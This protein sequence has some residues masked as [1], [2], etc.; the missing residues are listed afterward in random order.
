MPSFTTLLINTCNIQAKTQSTGSYEKIKTWAT[1]LSGVR[2][3]K[4]TSSG[5]ISDTELRTNIDDDIFFFNSD[6][7]V[8]RGNRIIFDTDAYDVVKVNKIYD[9]IGLHHLEVM[10]RFVDHD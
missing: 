8:K 5:N 4:D 9:A 10:T 3:R 6:V 7:A 1:F 2:C